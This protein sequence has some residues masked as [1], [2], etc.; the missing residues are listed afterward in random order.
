MY[1]FKIKGSF[2]KI[3]NSSFQYFF[4]V[5]AYYVLIYK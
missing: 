2:L 5:Y 3:V 1:L 4:Y